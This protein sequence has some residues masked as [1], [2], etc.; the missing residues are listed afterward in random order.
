[1]MLS[2]SRNNILIFLFFLLISYPLFYFCYKFGN[3]EMGGSDYFDYYKLYSNWNYSAVESPFNT[4]IISPFLVYLFGKLHIFYDTQIAFVKA[5]YS[6]RIYFNAVFVNYLC[7]VCTCFVIYKTIETFVRSRLLAILG[8]MV[9]L[10]GFGTSFYDLTGLTDAFSSLLFAIVLY[11]YFSK[12]RYILLVLLLSI[13]QREY[14]LMVLGL[15][16]GFD[17]VFRKES[18]KFHLETFIACIV[19]FTAYF[20]LRKTVFLT[21]LFQNQLEV[22]TYFGRLLNPAT[23]HWP[24]FIRQTILSQNLVFIYLGILIVKRVRHR[25]I[26][27]SNLILTLLLFIQANVINFLAFLGNNGGRCYYMIMPLIMYFAALEAEPLIDHFFNRKGS[28]LKSFQTE[29][30]GDV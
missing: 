24:E 17:W 8:G 12:S 27:T 21:P 26:N 11:A 1:M 5:G 30:P 4:R 2:G 29:N 18:R 28:E 10:F 16:A 9:Y 20:V 14:I 13:I 19:F 3:P 23:I 25:T 7:L 22:G 15:M 6:P